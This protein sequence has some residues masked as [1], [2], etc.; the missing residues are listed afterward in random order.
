M[1]IT[2]SGVP[3]SG[4][5]TVARL[6]AARLGVPHV[7][8]G[9]LYRQEAKRRG[10]SLAAF[11][12]LCERDHS[13]DRDLDAAMSARARQGDV[14][15]EGRLAG[16]LAAENGLDAL[17]VWLDASDETRARRVA[18]REG[19]DWRAVLEVNRLRHQSDAKRYQAIYGY[20][21]ADH[22]VYDV[23]LATDDRT[24]EELVE[25]LTDAARARFDGAIR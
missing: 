4:K 15:L 22:G 16:F 24:P 6:L 19:S 7:Y 20:D 5:T 1:L 10:L 9:D 3:G 23:I 21:L 2:I 25:T 8:A 12:A 13:I 18:Q 14:V 11:N 17:K